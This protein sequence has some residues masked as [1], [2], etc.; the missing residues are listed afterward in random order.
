VSA[1]HGMLTPGSEALRSSARDLQAPVVL[2][3]AGLPA[4]FVEPLSSPDLLAQAEVLRQLTAVLEETRTETVAVLHGMIHNAPREIRHALLEIKRLCHNGREVFGSDTAIARPLFERSAPRVANRLRDLESSLKA[5]RCSFERAFRNR[6]ASQVQHLLACLDNCNLRQGISLGSPDVLEN[7]ARLRRPVEAFRRK[8]ERLVESLVRYVSRAGLKLSPFSTLTQI[9][10]GDVRELTSEAQ[11]ELCLRGSTQR[12]LRRVNKHMVVKLCTLLREHPV[13][14]SRL[15][16]QVNPTVQQVGSSRYRFIEPFHWKLNVE[17]REFRY[18]FESQVSAGLRGPLI[19]ALLD[20]AET[21]KPHDQLVAELS[22]S[23]GAAPALIGE[24]VRKLIELSFL[25]LHFPWAT[26]SFDPERALLS[27]LQTLPDDLT[28]EKLAQALSRLLELRDTPVD[29][30]SHAELCREIDRHRQLSYKILSDGLGLPEIREPDSRQVNEDVLVLPGEEATQDVIGLLSRDSVE[31]ALSSAYPLV[32]YSDL[33]YTRYEFLHSLAALAGSHW[34]GRAEVSFL[35]LFHL[36]QPLWGEYVTEASA[37]ITEWKPELWNPFGL[38]AIEELQVLRAR[39]LADMSASMRPEDDELVIDFE[40]AHAAVARIPEI[41]RPAF[42]PCLLVQRAFADDDLWVL[43]HLLDGT[44]RFSN[45]YASAMQPDLRARFSACLREGSKGVK[46]GG[47]PAEMVEIL[48]ARDDHLN[49]HS[50][51]TERVLELPGENPDLPADRKIRLRDLQVRLD[52][53]LPVLTDTAGQ[54]LLPVFLGTN[55]LV[56]MPT[57]VRFLS[58]FGIGEFRLMHP[59]RP[60]KSSGP[61]RCYRR[62][63]IGNLVLRR[64]LWAF[65]PAECLGDW[66]ALSDPDL[67]LKIYRWCCD[68]GVPKQVFAAERLQT[69]F[70]L[71]PRHKPQFIDFTS[72]VFMPVLRS[73]LRSNPTELRLEEVLPEPSAFAVDEAGER[74]ALEA[75][76]DGITLRGVASGYLHHSR[77]SEPRERS[78]AIL[79]TDS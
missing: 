73:V 34:P 8:E 46:L 44:G 7:S 19:D 75:Q 42:G 69:R 79:G 43:N 31:R 18:F 38:A 1:G 26:N 54:R 2:R 40:S 51:Q 48:C 76:L 58:R 23:L 55:G 3:L 36:A 57:M 6:F 49:V 20:S 9:G 74:W 53:P 22:E 71:W 61:V 16:V 65:S 70:S 66:T 12:Q 62:L 4:S 59:P 24:V 41:Y 64:R 67:L 72:P 39:V 29:S 50:V 28:L 17:A 27:Y 33:N 5:E 13:F 35:E 77:S 15:L 56:G 60:E 52:G 21:H 10:L 11:V 63:R 45:R 14:R 68:H 47:E 25:I 32:L 78:P 30:A 37:A